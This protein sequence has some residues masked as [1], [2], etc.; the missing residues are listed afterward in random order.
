MILH[1]LLLLGA[2]ACFVLGCYYEVYLYLYPAN[3][4]YYDANYGFIGPNG[5]ARLNGYSGY[6]GLYGFNNGVNNYNLAYNGLLRGLF[7]APGYY[8][9]T[10]QAF[11]AF[12]GIDVIFL[13][14]AIVVVGCLM[15]RGKYH[16]RYESNPTLYKTSPVTTRM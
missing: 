5:N 8:N 10:G 14:V 1:V 6:N 16:D 4:A 2:L 3:A 13:I 12:L 15:R 11:L 9:Q 7:G